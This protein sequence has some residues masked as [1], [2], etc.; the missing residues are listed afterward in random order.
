MSEQKEIALFTIEEAGKLSY[1]IKFYDGSM[2][3]W[4]FI[5]VPNATINPD[6]V[7]V[8]YIAD[9]I[10][11]VIVK[12]TTNIGTWNSPENPLRRDPGEKTWPPAPK[13]KMIKKNS[14]H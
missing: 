7:T 12:F 14:D 10:K 9:I 11:E 6:E 8:E 2:I 5:P 4:T 3:R 13:K 1:L